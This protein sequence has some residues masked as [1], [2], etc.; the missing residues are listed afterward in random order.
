MTSSGR[1]AHLVVVL[2]SPMRVGLFHTESGVPGIYDAVQIILD[3]GFG[4]IGN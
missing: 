3:L 1:P 2:F 4:R